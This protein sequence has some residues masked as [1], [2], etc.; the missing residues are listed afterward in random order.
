M[1]PI[2][3][4]VLVALSIVGFA[5]AFIFRSRPDAPD[6]DTWDVGHVEDGATFTGDAHVVSIKFASWSI[7]SHPLDEWDPLGGVLDCEFKDEW[8]DSMKMENGQMQVQGRYRE[9][10]AGFERLP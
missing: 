3:A 7:E 10:Y 5:L 6:V 2:V 1:V 4:G 9:G 8:I